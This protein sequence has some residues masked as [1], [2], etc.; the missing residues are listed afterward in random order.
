MGRVYSHVAS[1]LS[2]AGSEVPAVPVLE[3]CQ[4]LASPEDAGLRL[5]QI[6]DRH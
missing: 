5:I 4:L 3:W 2:R 6:L 1:R